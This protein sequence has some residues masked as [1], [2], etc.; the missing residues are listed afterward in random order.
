MTPKQIE[1]ALKLRRLFGAATTCYKCNT[2]LPWPEIVLWDDKLPLCN[3]CSKIW[4]RDF[5]RK[6]RALF[7]IIPSLAPKRGPK[8]KPP[9]SEE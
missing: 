7:V 2:H 3:W 4:K 8:P 6:A 5:G 9:K 1:H